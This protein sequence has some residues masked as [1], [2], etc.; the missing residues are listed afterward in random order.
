MNINNFEYHINKTIVDRG[1]NYYI[2]GNVVEAFKKGESEYIFH[3]E[4]STEYEVVVEMGDNGEILHSKCDCPYDI[5]PVCK[6]E[7]AAYFQLFEMLN[8]KNI[9][10]K[11]TTNQQKKRVT[12][13]EVLDPLSKEELIDIIVNIAQNETTLQNSLIVKYSNGD[14]QQELEAC[15]ELIQAIVRK[16]TGRNGFVEYRDTG[17]FV[18]ELEDVAEKA[19]NTDD[20]LLALD[21]ALLLL[22]EGINAFQYADD[23]NGNIGDLV[24]DTLEV[25]AEIAHTCKETG[26]QKAEIFEKLLALTDNE[27]FDEWVD[28]QIDLLHICFEFADDPTLREQLKMKI[29]SMLGNPSSNR[30]THYSNENIL[31]LLFRLIKQYGTREEAEQFIYDHLQFS[32]FREELLNKCIQKKNFHKVIE[33]AEEG[34]KQDQQYSG[35]IT[36]WKK[37]RYTAYKCLGLKKEQQTLAR[38]L[39]LQGDFEYYQDLKELAAENQKEFYTHLKQELK[40]AKGWT[41]SRIFLKLIEKENDLEEMLKLVQENPGY[42]ENY[43]EKLVNYFK[44]DVINIYKEYII[45][46]ARTSSNRRDYQGVCSKIARYK[47]IAGKPKQEELIS[48]LKGLYR[49]RPAFIDELGKIIKRR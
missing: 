11:A 3:I 26:Y 40:A 16:Y 44:E 31:Q 21:I 17:A 28:Y 23:S 27:L 22:E 25:I 37:F 10:D 42:I 5:G 1:Y 36:K 14:S 34:E 29:E 7:V 19:K 20:V 8:N 48:E 13:Q 45:S 47:K 33:I 38:E 6:H 9:N 49:K 32:F 39:L 35:L 2:E 30:Y 15:Q 24:S 41:T 46:A 43:A 12:L 4:G 18:T